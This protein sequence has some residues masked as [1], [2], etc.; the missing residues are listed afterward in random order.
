MLTT[1]IERICTPG[2][3]VDRTCLDSLFHSGEVLERV[4]RTGAPKVVRLDLRAGERLILKLWYPKGGITSEAIFHYAT[5]FRRHAAR[6]RRKAVAAP[7]PRGWGSVNGTRIRFVCYPEIAGRT[8]REWIPRVDLEA[9]GVFV[10]GLH[11]GGIDFR[12]LHMG[13]ILWSGGDRFGLIDV[14]DCYFPWFMSRRRRLKRLQFFCAHHPERAYLATDGN[15]RRFV[16]AYCESAGLT[17]DWML[18][19]V[20][21]RLGQH[22][23]P[24]T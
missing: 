13:N 21:R 15:W 10:A 11:D 16:Q 7:D 4:R 17:P 1:H 6:L 9:V 5:R 24:T 22:P 19:H 18:E 14:T 2:A 3:R 23:A 12:S 20:A 8:L